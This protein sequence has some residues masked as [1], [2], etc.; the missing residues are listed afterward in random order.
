VK[1]GKDCEGCALIDR[2]RAANDLIV[3]LQHVVRELR[4]ELGNHE[5]AAA[6][7]PGGNVSDASVVHEGD[8]ERTSTEGR[9]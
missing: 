8:G 6:G 1:F 2:L 3:E 9:Q 5:A 7:W 4:D